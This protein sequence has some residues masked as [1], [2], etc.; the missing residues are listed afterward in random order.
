MTELA[1][2]K[3]LPEHDRNLIRADSF[4]TDSSDEQSKVID[5]QLS[6]DSSVKTDSQL[7]DEV[8]EGKYHYKT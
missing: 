5:I 3:E 6:K 8:E 4:G 7:I 2:I 1:P